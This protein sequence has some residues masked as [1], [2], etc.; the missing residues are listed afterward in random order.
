MRLVGYLKKSIMMHSNMNVKD[1]ILSAPYRL[2]LPV[3]LS[4]DKQWID[5]SP[6]RALNRRQEVING[7]GRMKLDDSTH[8]SSH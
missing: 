2:S 3:R 6:T 8:E 4:C 7:S 5:G 1:I